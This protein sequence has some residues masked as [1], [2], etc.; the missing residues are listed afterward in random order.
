MTRKLG[1]IAIAAA[2]LASV[3]ASVLVTSSPAAASYECTYGKVCLYTGTFGNGARWEAPHC[4][5]TQL[6]AGIAF[7]T[8]SVRTYGNAVQLLWLDQD[9]QGGDWLQSGYVGQWVETNLDANTADLTSAVNV[10]C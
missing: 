7:H 4:G 10:I 1:K 8:H 6:P 3:A 2:M 5:F 9:G